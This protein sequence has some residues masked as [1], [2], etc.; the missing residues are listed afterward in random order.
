MAYFVVFND[1]NF[2]FFKKKLKVYKTKQDLNEF[3]TLTS[4]LFGSISTL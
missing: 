3:R 1:T 4:L 2:P